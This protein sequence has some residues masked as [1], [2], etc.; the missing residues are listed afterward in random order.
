MELCSHKNVRLLF[1]MAILIFNI[2]PFKIVA[3]HNNNWAIGLMKGVS[4]N[5]NTLKIIKTKVTHDDTLS[6][7][8]Q[9]LTKSANSTCSY[10]NCNGELIVYGG[11]KYLWNKNNK[12]LKNAVFNTDGYYIQPL[13][14]HPNNT[15]FLYYFYKYSIGNSPCYDHRLAYAIIDLNGDN[16]L[17]EVIKKDIILDSTSNPYGAL[18]N[19]IAFTFHKNEKDIWLIYG[20]SH[21]TAKSYLLTDSGFIHKAVVSSNIKSGSYNG[22]SGNID[23]KYYLSN[24]SQAGQFKTTND[25][26][27]LIVSGIDSSTSKAGPCLIYDF[28]NETGKLSN[29][30]TLLQFS[31]I[32]TP[33]TGGTM[34]KGNF[35]SVEVAPNDTLIY[36]ASALL[37]SN[38]NGPPTWS[39][40]ILQ[41]NRFTRSIVYVRKLKYLTQGLQIGPD[42]KIYL[43]YRTPPSGALYRIPFP[44]RKGSSSGF[45]NIFEDSTLS[46]VYH[47][48]SVLKPNYK[49]YYSSNLSGNPCLDT[50]LFNIHVDKNFR[51]LKIFFGDGD[52][53]IYNSPLNNSYS[54]KHVYK[55][56]GKYF[57]NIRGLNPDCDFYTFNGDTIQIFRAPQRLS[58]TF[59]IEKG[60]QNS[61]LT[62][63]NLYLETSKSEY[64]WQSFPNDTFF[65]GQE[66][67]LLIQSIKNFKTE[68]PEILLTQLWNNNCPFPTTY[69]DTFSPVF[70]PNLKIEYKLSSINSKYNLDQYLKKPLFKGCSPFKW[71]Y[72]DLSNGLNTGSMQVGD[73][74]YSFKA[75]TLASF[76][77]HEGLIKVIILDTSV[78]GCHSTDT[79]YIEGIKSPKL[80]WQFVKVD[81]CLNQNLIQLKPISDN[82]NDNLT[83]LKWGDA[84]SLVLKN[85]SILSHRYTSS[86]RYELK[87]TSTKFCSIDVDTLIRIHDNP[88]AK[89]TI[90]PQSLCFGLDSIT[91]ASID[92]S[93]HYWDLGDLNSKNLK[94]FKYRYSQAGMY[95]VAHYVTNSSNCKDTSIQTLNVTETP[96]SRFSISDSTQC[97]NGNNF[98]V[99]TSSLYSKI[100]LLKQSI[101]W[102]D[103]T[104]D[105]FVG[106]N[107]QIHQFAKAGKYTIQLISTSELNCADTSVTTVTV[108]PNPIIKLNINDK[109]FGD[110]SIL[111]A[112]EYSGT[113]IKNFDWSIN[114]TTI[115]NNKNK[116]HTLF[117][118]SGAYKIIITATSVNECE[119]VDSMD[120]NIL[121]KP[122]ADF[123]VINIG[124][125]GNDY[126][127]KFNNLS[128]FSNKWYWKIGT[129]DTSM[130]KNPLLY[131]SDTGNYFIKL[132][133]SNSDICFDTIEKLIPVYGKFNFYFPNT[134]TPNKN[135]INDEFGL[136]PYQLYWVN[137]Y[138]MKIYNRWGELVF[139]TNDKFEMW[140]GNSAQ[141]GVYIYKAMIRDFYNI[142]HEYKG[143]IELIK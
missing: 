72:E 56:P 136:S 82:Y 49:L 137:E 100:G 1:C 45:E 133:A 101:V 15:R 124:P 50:G 98:S 121:N 126:R 60:C 67:T 66:D 9:D 112:N 118:S 29:E 33:F 22:C 108:K 64:F 53:V 134:F 129:I 89:F 116:L 103:L 85:D 30:D 78:F 54:I 142:L 21:T 141:Q 63:S 90:F 130:T 23:S 36:F 55:K 5:E 26:K 110:T 57:F 102:N 105:N 13:L 109:C 16:G 35:F 68:N 132:I 12:P 59:R 51:T 80:N 8:I 4:F 71:E 83:V 87:L 86:S 92:T 40:N 28:D 139:K 125:L 6:N 120:L 75:N 95:N 119:G 122:K 74:I 140:D 42:G 128:Q 79:F 84:D 99:S 43:I 52:S 115:P 20:S 31:D 34:L 96:Q 107:I 11:G 27:K 37:Y 58:T 113:M 123:N 93:I 114:K 117:P 44:N 91:L 46:Y 7:Y 94:H 17:G 61:L 138:S 104:T 38:P 135:N 106:N 127:F 25:G 19:N 81:S 41:L 76:H 73:S 24:T 62:L 10:S 143:V 14:M 69:S 2:Q 39:A 3:Q 47:F 111:S 88:N 18:N 70:Y 131:F 65:K 32:P 77:A 97:L 48:P